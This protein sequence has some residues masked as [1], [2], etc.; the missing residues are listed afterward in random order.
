M[1]GNHREKWLGLVFVMAMLLFVSAGEKAFAAEPTTAKSITVQLTTDFGTSKENVEFKLYQ[2]GSWNPQTERWTLNDALSSTNVVFSDL[3]DVD[4]WKTAAEKLAQAE[5]LSS[6]TPKPGTTDADGICIFTIL[7]YGMYLIMQEGAN[8]YG[9]IAP[10]LV[11]LP[12]KANGAAYQDSITVT[13]KA[14]KF[15]SSSENTSGGN[16]GSS[17][18]KNESKENEKKQE[19]LPQLILVSPAPEQPKESLK[20]PELKEFKEKTE[21]NQEES[22]QLPETEEPSQEETEEEIPEEEAVP[23]KE[24]SQETVAEEP[25]SDGISRILILT[26]TGAATIVIVFVTGRILILKKRV[27]R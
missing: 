4:A 13:P 15:P 6:L 7:D 26:G 17:S 23:E 19:D 20:A 11:S 9:T 10:F 1:K 2:V 16:S 24:P 22:K 25:A 12:Y 18:G 3:T 21:E 8:S 5:G 14:E 27:K